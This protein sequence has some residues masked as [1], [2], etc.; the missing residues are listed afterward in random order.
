[1]FAIFDPLVIKFFD[2][3]FDLETVSAILGFVQFSR[4]LVNESRREGSRHIHSD[5]CGRLLCVLETAYEFAQFPYAKKIFE[6]RG[7]YCFAAK[8]QK[9]TGKT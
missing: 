8:L 3:S 6:K 7:L 9:Q 4:F 2:Q 1:M 5:T